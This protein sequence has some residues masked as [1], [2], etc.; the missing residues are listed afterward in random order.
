MA[1]LPGWRV[2]DFETIPGPAQIARN[3]MKHHSRLLAACLATAGLLMFAAPQHAVAKSDGLSSSDF[4]AAKKNVKKQNVKK[5]KKAKRSQVY[6]YGPARSAYGFRPG[7]RSDPSFDP[8]GR[9]WRP[10]FYANCYEDLGYG[11]FR[12]CADIR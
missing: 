8:Y 10:N 12:D 1:A 5:Q 11:R 7:F 6:I 9:P 3:V 2:S 4:S